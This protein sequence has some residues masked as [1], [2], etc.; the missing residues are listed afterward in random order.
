MFHRLQVWL[1]SVLLGFE[2]IQNEATE[3]SSSSF[4]KED[5]KIP[6]QMTT[7]FGFVLILDNPAKSIAY[8]EF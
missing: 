8:K 1:D 6:Y 5:I 7:V 3:F 2:F 4:I